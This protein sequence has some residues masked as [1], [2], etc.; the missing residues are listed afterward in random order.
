MSFFCNFGAKFAGAL[1]FCRRPNGILLVPCNDKAAKADN[2]AGAAKAVKEAKV[3]R[4]ARQQGQRRERWEL[5][6]QRS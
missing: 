4:H 5:Q 6:R 1:V 2:A 3:R